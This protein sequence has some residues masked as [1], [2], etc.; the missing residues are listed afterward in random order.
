MTGIIINDKLGKT[1]AMFTVTDPDDQLKSL[2]L[3]EPWRWTSID[4]DLGTVQAIALM[5][6]YDYDFNSILEP[7]VGNCPDAVMPAGIP[8]ETWTLDGIYD[9]EKLFAELREYNEP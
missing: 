1:V 9:E 6:L 5:V 7:P 2:C 8:V 4:P 3:D